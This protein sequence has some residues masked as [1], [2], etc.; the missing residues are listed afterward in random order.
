M[1]SSIFNFIFLVERCARSRGNWC[2]CDSRK[3]GASV[4]WICGRDDGPRRPCVW[5][6]LLGQVAL[7]P[8]NWGDPGHREFQYAASSYEIPRQWINE[9][10][11]VPAKKVPHIIAMNAEDMSPYVGSRMAS[12]IYDRIYY[13]SYAAIFTE[14]RMF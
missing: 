6:C 3:E 5:F 10:K 13:G 8:R 12:H 2:S 11:K 4:N 7:Y 9:G 1:Q 14:L